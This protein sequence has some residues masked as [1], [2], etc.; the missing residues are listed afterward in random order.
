MVVVANLLLA[1]EN[2]LLLGVALSLMVPALIPIIILTIGLCQS[3]PPGNF[4]RMSARCRPV[5]LLIIL[6]GNLIA[7]SVKI[8][9]TT[10]PGD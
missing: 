4:A 1:G 9:I 3:I 7:T 6:L 5:L 8:R 10:C 2:I